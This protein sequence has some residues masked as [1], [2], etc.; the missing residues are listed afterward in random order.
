M[1]F[2][3]IVKYVLLVIFFIAATYI[4][5]PNLVKAIQCRFGR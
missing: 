2:F 5:V 3:E 1:I 4:L